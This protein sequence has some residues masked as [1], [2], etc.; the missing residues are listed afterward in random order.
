M[1]PLLLLLL[2]LATCLPAAHSEEGL[3]ACTRSGSM[4][5]ASNATATACCQANGTTCDTQVR[6]P[7]GARPPPGSVC[8]PNV[9]PSQCH[10]C[11]GPPPPPHP[12][13]CVGSGAVCSKTAP[14]CENKGRCSSFLGCTKGGSKGVY[15]CQ[16]M[17]PPQP[18]QAA[19]PKKNLSHFEIAK[20]VF[21]PWLSNGAVG[22]PKNNTEQAA[23][24]LWLKQGGRGV[25]TAWSYHN[26]VQ[27]GQAMRNSAVPRPDIFLTT[28]IPCVGSAAAAMDYIKRDQAQLCGGM[29]GATWCE[30]QPFADLILI[31]EA[32]ASCKT[33][34]MLQATW[35]GMEMALAANLTR[36][37]GVSNF[38]VK[39][40]ET[41]LKTAKITPAANQC[42]M[43]IG[44]HDDATI[45]FCKEKGILYE[46]Y[47]PLGGPDLHG[48][49]VMTYPEV[50]RIAAVHHVSG[51]QVAMRWVLQQGCAV[52]T[53]TGA[54]AY[55]GEDLAVTSF[56]LTQSEMES[57]SKVTGN[58]P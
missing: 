15:T 36:S 1:A 4:C 43:H 25:D 51:A 47:S 5:G 16:F 42:S 38:N 41:V 33:E 14:C 21:M 30:G 23:I 18:Q 34:A 26:Q 35:K 13:G 11:Q 48:K 57:L 6:C 28:K 53:A 12:S 55:M 8:G 27:V 37:I 49:A 9:E 45:A 32:G 10:T 29:P 22:F 50:K 58:P 24:E 40:L 19:S 17:P 44:R 3:P 39:N 54:A 7:S 46:A 52:V 31:H 20:G 56:E 2:L